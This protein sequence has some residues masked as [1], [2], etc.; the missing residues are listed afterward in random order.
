[1]SIKIMSAVFESIT[2]SPTDRLVM[3]SLADHA[4]DDGSCYP[5]VG[6][7]CQRTGLGE[8]A[9]QQTIKRLRDAGHIS[10]K[11]GGGRGNATLYTLHINPAPE[12]PFIKPR[13]RNPVSD[14]INPAYCALN[15]APDAPEPLRTIKE[16][17]VEKK[18]D[19]PAE[20]EAWASPVAVASFLA[21]RR[22]H[23]SKA[24]SLT[25][26]KRLAGHLRK[27]FDNGGDCD[28]ALAMIEEKGWASIEP[29]WYFK[30][31]GQ[32]N[33]NAS[34]ANSINSRGNPGFRT[35]HDDLLAGFQRAASRDDPWAKSVG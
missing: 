32:T 24:L 12:T 9:V 22:R 4:G 27:I 3:L 26:A 13:T 17:S 16:P 14:D 25:G 31:K 23:K 29:D 5:S 19:V 30:A 35:G 15:P 21:Y 2:L 7:L 28:D 34:Q 8:R 18:E 11:I 20:L 33:G 1:M 10:T 6:R